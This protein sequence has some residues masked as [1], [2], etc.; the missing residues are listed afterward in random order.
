MPA[1]ITVTNS[2]TS[3]RLN[4]RTALYI[5]WDLEVENRKIITKSDERVWELEN[6]LL[7]IL[8]FLIILLLLLKYLSGEMGIA[9]YFYIGM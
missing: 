8:N 7:Y 2:Y 1:Y 9:K 6:I 3:N 4:G 5:S